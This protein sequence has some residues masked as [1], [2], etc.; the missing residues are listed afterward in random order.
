MRCPSEVLMVVWYKDL[1]YSRPQN[2]ETKLCVFS[3]VYL[4]RISMQSMVASET[5]H[6]TLFNARVTEASELVLW[7]GGGHSEAIL[8]CSSRLN[9]SQ[10]LSNIH[11]H[12]IEV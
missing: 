7:G 8:Y 5:R 1:R 4:A 3:L 2:L 9:L 11:L 12:L 6:S 10:S